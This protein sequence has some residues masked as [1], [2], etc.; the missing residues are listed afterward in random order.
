[1]GRC[2]ALF[3]MPVFHLPLLF[4]CGETRLAEH[5][6][7]PPRVPYVF[8]HAPRRRLVLEQDATEK[9]SAGV[10]ADDVVVEPLSK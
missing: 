9:Q 7:L 4:P 10:D 1:M 8:L 5:E 3:R 6:V 2:C